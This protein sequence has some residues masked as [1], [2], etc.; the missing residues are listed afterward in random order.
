[1][2]PLPGRHFGPSAASAPESP[3]EL[4]PP[5]GSIGDVRQAAVPEASLSVT[6]EAVAA[7]T[8]LV[9]TGAAWEATQVQVR[10]RG[11]VFDAMPVAG[12]WVAT[13]PPAA[14]GPADGELESRQWLVRF[15]PAC[16]ALIGDVRESVVEL[17]ADDLAAITVAVAGVPRDAKWDVTLTPTAVVAKHVWGDRELWLAALAATPRTSSGSAIWAATAH[18]AELG[19]AATLAV[20]FPRGEALEVA[21]SAPDHDIEPGVE[22]VRAPHALVGRVVRDS[23]QIAVLGTFAPGDRVVLQ[24]DR[25]QYDAAIVVATAATAVQLP[26]PSGGLPRAAH[27]V[28]LAATG[29]LCR[30][31]VPAGAAGQVLLPPLAVEPRRCPKTGMAMAMAVRGVRLLRGKSWHTCA[32]DADTPFVLNAWCDHVADERDAVRIASLDPTWLSAVVQLADGGLGIVDGAAVA[33]HAAEP[34]DL[35]V[36]V[37]LGD[38][39]QRIAWELRLVVRNAPDVALLGGQCSLRELRALRPAACRQLPHRLWVNPLPARTAG[40]TVDAPF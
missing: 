6:S 12:R 4:A 32:T 1:V 22:V 25:L 27:V 36:P 18:A 35:R 15:G 29:V 7:V 11:R 24:T 39:D 10:Q 3:A 17:A 20:P 37:A 34:V 13:L 19:A 38:D 16:V 23:G 9:V 30:A 33:W 31:Q 26:L 40:V 8:A 28:H 2:S 14:A 5:V 21:L